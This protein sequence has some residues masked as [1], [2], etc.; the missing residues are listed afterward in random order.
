MLNWKVTK[1]VL[2]LFLHKNY[3]KQTEKTSLAYS[4]KTK[5]LTQIG[6]TLS[7]FLKFKKTGPCFGASL[8]HHILSLLGR[9]QGHLEME[10]WNEKCQAERVCLNGLS[11]ILAK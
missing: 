3:L 10:I 11:M 7:R 6:F 5:W 4:P 2:S 1:L 9:K 8:T